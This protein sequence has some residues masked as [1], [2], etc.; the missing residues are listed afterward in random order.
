MHLEISERAYEKGKSTAPRS[1]YEWAHRELG[2]VPETG[3][4]NVGYRQ[5]FA[6]VI[7]QLAIKRFGRLTVDAS[8]T[9]QRESCQIEE[10]DLRAN[11]RLHLTNCY[12]GTIQ[13]QATVEAT[14]HLTNC[15]VG[16]LKFEN[17]GYRHLT[18]KSGGIH[19]VQAG[20]GILVTGDTLIQGTWIPRKQIDNKPSLHALRKVRTFFSKEN[21]S[22]AAG[23]FHAAELAI[24]RPNESCT[25]QAVSRIYDIGCSYGNSPNRAL[26]CFLIVLGAIVLLDA[27][28]SAAVL[29]D[30][31]QAVGWQKSL[32]CIGADPVSCLGFGERILKGLLLAGQLILNPLGVFGGKSLLVLRDTS[33]LIPF[34]TLGLIGLLSVAMFF[35]SIRRRFKLD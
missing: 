8:R 11:S 25:N 1:R 16:V 33:L 4:V 23:Y 6:E 7:D 35:I 3:Y 9:F 19:D 20:D 5:D 28:L 29:A 30:P 27:L 2:R 26:L 24:E 15:W 32:H 34:H 21:H 12:I 18:I 22:L 10:V 14:I 31:S 13:P 17:K